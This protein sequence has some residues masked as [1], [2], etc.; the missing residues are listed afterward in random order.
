MSI[1]LLQASLVLQPEVSYILALKH[2]LSSA[3]E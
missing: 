3:L 2:E 1:H